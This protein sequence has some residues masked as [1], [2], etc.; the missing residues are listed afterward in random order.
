MELKHLVTIT[1]IRDRKSFTAAA[2]ALGVTQAAVSQHVAMLE[3]ELG[4]ELF[5]RRGRQVKLTAAGRTLCDRADEILSLVEDAK[6]DVAGYPR[7]VSGVLQ[8]ASSTVPAATFLP[9]FLSDFQKQFPE[10]RTELNVSE[11]HSTILAVE[12]ESADIGFVGVQPQRST[13]QSLRVADDEL[14][15]IV[16]S[17]DPLAQRRLIS[18][19]QLAQQPLIVRPPNSGSRRALEEAL[20]KSG[21]SLAEMQVVM[22]ANSNDAILA[23]V[24]QGSGIA[25]L[26]AAVVDEQLQAKRIHVLKVRGLRPRRSLFMITRDGVDGREPLNA[27]VKFVRESVG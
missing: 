13:L 17:D 8:I 21:S 2:R 15:L 4:V 23:A 16:N 20:K 1:T 22:E 27:F 6:A 9:R 10:V 19:K 26:S 24:R 11:S 7:S 25:F 18:V 14:S 5:D 12:R 3:D